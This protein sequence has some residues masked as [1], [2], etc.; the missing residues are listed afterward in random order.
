MKLWV[1]FPGIL[2]VSIPISYSKGFP[3]VES[4]G[5]R[6]NISIF[7]TA[8]GPKSEQMLPGELNGAPS[9]HTQTCILANAHIYV[10][11]KMRVWTVKT[12]FS[13]FKFQQ[14]LHN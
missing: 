14:S 4:N 13:F 11:R 3:L 2:D 12:A 7:V 10:Q 9:Y 5:L 1:W 8:I 6:Y